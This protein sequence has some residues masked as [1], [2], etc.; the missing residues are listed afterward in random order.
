ME[1]VLL[2]LWR[3]GGGYEVGCVCFANRRRG[4]RCVGVLLSSRLSRSS[5]EEGRWASQVR[6]GKGRHGEVG[7]EVMAVCEVMTAGWCDVLAALRYEAI[8]KCDV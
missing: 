7:S 6:G 5:N 2:C 1:R 8:V 4:H 3:C